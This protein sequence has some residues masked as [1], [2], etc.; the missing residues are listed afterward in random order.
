MRLALAVV[1]SSTIV[2]P[3]VL[4][5]AALTQD[6]DNPLLIPVLYGSLLFSV[7]GVAIVGLPTHFILRSLGRRNWYFYALV[8]FGIP[9]LVVLLTHPFG[10]DGY[11]TILL[12]T[13]QMGVLG[14]IAALAF[15]RIAVPR[16]AD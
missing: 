6:L 10:E 13:I 11:P 16:E 14:T 12:Q 2:A 5:F 9:A 3:I 8:G 7:L 4:L 1:V 15:W